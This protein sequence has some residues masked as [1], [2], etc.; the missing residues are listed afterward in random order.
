[1]QNDLKKK[2]KK[3]E[4]LLKIKE[5]HVKTKLY[6][7]SQINHQGYKIGRKKTS[8]IIFCQT[9]NEHNSNIE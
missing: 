8:C 9:T 3:K 2:D 7:S 1:M 4:L 6:R 5:R